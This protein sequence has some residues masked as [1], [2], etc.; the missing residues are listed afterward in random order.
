MKPDTGGTNIGPALATIQK[1]FGAKRRGASAVFI[2]TQSRLAGNVNG[3][4]GAIRNMR[5]AGTKVFSIGIGGS[6][7]LGQVR[8]LAGNDRNSFSCLL[9]SQVG[10][11]MMNMQ[12]WCLRSKFIFKLV[13]YGFIN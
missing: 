12:F 5:I 4:Y 3:L 10:A 9:P 6:Y 1:L 8:G 7:D 11:S 2:L 13:M